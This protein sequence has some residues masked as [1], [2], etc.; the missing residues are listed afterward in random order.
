MEA[1][2]QRRVSIEKSTPKPSN[3]C[4]GFTLIELMVVVAIVAVIGVFAVPAFVSFIENNRIKTQSSEFLSSLALARIE[5]VK[6]SI[7]VVVCP[8]TTSG[9]SGSAW[10]DGWVVFADTNANGTPDSGE[11]SLAVHGALAGSN[12]LRGNTPLANRIS[13]YPDGLVSELDDGDAGAF[14]LC[15]PADA[16]N[17]WDRSRIILVSI[18]GRTRIATSNTDGLPV[19]KCP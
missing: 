6:R 13:F 8:G 19:D 3:T 17:R 12:E 9:C 18:I 16:S 15:L 2:T 5:A 11:T 14:T 10:E 4:S 1:G 7:P